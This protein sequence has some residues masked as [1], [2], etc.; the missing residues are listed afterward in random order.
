M[1]LLCKHN[2]NSRYTVDMPALD[3]ILEEAQSVLQKNNNGVFTIPASGIY[4]H[5]WLWDS[6]FI[7][8]GLRHYDVDRAQAE[9]KSLL[10]GQWK[11]GMI[12]HMMLMK[13]KK[14]TKHEYIWRS[15]L[16]PFSPNN[17][18]T[19]G[20]TQPPILSEAVYLV[21]QKLNAPERKSFYKRML[22]ELIRYHSWLYHERDP[23]DEGLLTILHPW[24]SG[25]D[26]SPALLESLRQN[27]FPLWLRL[28]EALHLQMLANLTRFDSK[29]GLHL[30]ERTE[31]IDELL[32]Y[33]LQRR[34]R[35]KRYHSIL[36]LRKPDFAVQEIGFN[37]IALRSNSSLQKIAETVHVT[38]PEKLRTK[39]ALAEKAIE[40]LW[41]P[42]SMQYCS[43]NFHTK[44]HIRLSTVANLL[45]LYSGVISK[46]RASQIITQLQN[47][48]KYA[49]ECPVPSVSMAEPKFDAR[50]YWQGPA[51]VNTNWMLIQGLEEYGSS[52][53]AEA[54]K[55]LTLRTVE[56]GGMREYFDAH[57]AKP[58]GAT[59]FSWTAA[60]AIDLIKD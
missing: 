44:Q 15:E 46:Q 27:H 29:R 18:G 56:R 60:L 58:L 37:S 6:C 11:N 1:F 7:A 42:T 43:R 59:D 34:L 23:R 33:T 55:T 47:E 41:D 8:I 39:F 28:L 12:P 45:P 35:A 5:Q 24:E 32:L 3:K 4:P 57:S 51:W 19:S 36:T 30:E 38:L 54:L 2:H 16:N 48:K 13:H 20:I 21:G 52:E 40:A 50:R 53:M 26:N 49:S 17:V 14:P 31:V 9:L 10:R 22:P 25:M